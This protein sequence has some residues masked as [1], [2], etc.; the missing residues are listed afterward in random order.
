MGRMINPNT[1]GNSLF[2]HQRLDE[3]E[4]ACRRAIAAQPADPSPYRNLG[5]LYQLQQKTEDAIAR[6]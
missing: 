1:L 3:A 4:Q 2:A 6:M 5:L